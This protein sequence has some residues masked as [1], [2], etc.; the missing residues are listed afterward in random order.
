MLILMA[1]FMFAKWWKFTMKEK[2]NYIINIFFNFQKKLIR[3]VMISNIELK[4]FQINF[5]LKLF[6][7]LMLES[8]EFIL[9]FYSLK[10]TFFLS[11]FLT[12]C[13]D[14][15]FWFLHFSLNLN[16]FLHFFPN[17]NCQVKKI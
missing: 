11:N 17:K 3:F 14:K 6:M 9:N 1:L 12:H 10:V 13:F 5:M 15:V 4:S 16:Y 7:C 8:L 2:F